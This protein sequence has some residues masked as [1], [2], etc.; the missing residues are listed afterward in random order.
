MDSAVK[1]KYII[2]TDVVTR[3]G[4]RFA[5]VNHLYV[6]VMSHKP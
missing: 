1:C 5:S 3:K 6:C 4:Q 2:A